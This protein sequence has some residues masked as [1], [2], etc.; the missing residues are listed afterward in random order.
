MVD[1]TIFRQSFLDLDRHTAVDRLPERFQRCLDQFPSHY[2][3]NSRFAPFAGDKMVI[4]TKARFCESSRNNDIGR[5]CV[6]RYLFNNPF[7]DGCLDQT[8]GD[9]YILHSFSEKE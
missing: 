8:V 5:K 1:N 3:R 2:G 7:E 6:G 9:I 4:D